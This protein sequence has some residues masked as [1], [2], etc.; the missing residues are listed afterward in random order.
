MKY[1]KE[2]KFLF[3]F[4]LSGILLFSILLLLS[5]LNINVGLEIFDKF[6]D[7]LIIYFVLSF[8]IFIP[9][10]SL[11]FVKEEIYR[12]WRLFA[13]IFFPISLFLIASAPEYCGAIVCLLTREAVTL[14]MSILFLIISFS[15]IAIKSWRLRGKLGKKGA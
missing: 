9:S 1:K 7:F 11:F 3:S 13:I 10:L 12:S 8:I 6:E 5:W 15:I 4:S 2:V 14:Y